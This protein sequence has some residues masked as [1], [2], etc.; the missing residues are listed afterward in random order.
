MIAL[1]MEAIDRKNQNRHSGH[2]AGRGSNATA[3]GCAIVQL[4]RSP[5]ELSPE[6]SRLDLPPPHK[7]MLF[8]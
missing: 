7:T 4:D 1:H 2:Y 6:R 3:D 8:A 5:P